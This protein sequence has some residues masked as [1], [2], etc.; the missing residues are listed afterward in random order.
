MARPGQLEGM[1]LLKWIVLLLFSECF[2]YK[3]SGFGPSVNVGVTITPDRVVAAIILVLAV[4]K[5]ACGRLPLTSLGGAGVCML[6]FAAICTT[7]A[8]VV[9]AGSS[10]LYRL[11]DFNYSP[12]IIFAVA[13]AIPHSRKKLEVVC[14]AFLAIGA[15]LTINGMFEYRGPHA[16]VWPRYILDP[17][18]GIQ[19]ERTRGSFGSSEILGQALT[20]CFL[21]YALYTTRVTGMK[22][23]ASMLLM[24]LTVVVI[25]A[26]GTRTGWVSFGLCV[27]CLA[28]TRSKMNRVARLF[29]VLVLL[30]FFGG[31][32]THFSFWEEATLFSRRQ[33]TVDYRRVNDLTTLEMAKANPVFGI[34]FGNF[35]NQWREYF[36]P[37]PGTGIRDL[38]DGN[39]NTFLGIFAEVGLLGLIPYLMLFGFMVKAALRVYRGG[40]R[41]E[42]EFATVFLLVVLTYVAGGT[43]GDYRSGPFFNTVLFL[44]FGTVQGI[45]SLMA[46]ALSRSTQPRAGWPI[47]SGRAGVRAG[48][49]SGHWSGSR[50]LGLNVS[51]L[52]RR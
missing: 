34:G 43:V 41:R 52:T 24:L 16:L 1:E 26:T 36:R 39:H 42:R 15:Y 9:G 29:I 33:N 32:T 45:P 28:M 6:A 10:V 51:R 4:R 8:L 48:Q 12:F 14:F 19:F 11:V 23:Y 7:S 27:A 49:C 31:L 22:L 30:G 44:L 13:M 35:R 17:H 46:P 20:V 40:E 5:A 37:I 3:G 25:Y 2:L 18:V 21:F 50:P 38:A 47:R